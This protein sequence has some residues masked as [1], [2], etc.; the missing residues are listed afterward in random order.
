[1]RI[2]FRDLTKS[3]DPRGP[4][5]LDGISCGI[6]FGHVLALLGPSGGGKSTLL[7]LIAGLD[8]A[9]RGGIEIDG[10][11]VPS[12]ERSLRE[13][14]KRL[15]VVF[16]SFNLFPHHTALR[17]VELP[18][19]AVHGRQPALARERAME[20]LERLGLADHASKRPDQ[21]SG[22][23]RQRVAIARALAPD[24]SL[25]LF[26][27]PTSSLDPEMTAEVLSLIAGLRESST[28][29]ILVTHEMGF[30]RKIADQVAFLAEGRI[31][32]SGSAEGFFRSPES[33]AARSFLAKVLAY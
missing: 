4:R 24:P 21:L 10:K 13:H 23:Q 5:V 26:D 3:F 17:N 30:A 8:P 7:R 14:R 6:T 22:G 27:E 12:D 9:D 16:Q 33:A 31:L 15:G 29:M 11:T 1:M 2:E 19:V 25:L 18:L 28:P 20:M 32:E